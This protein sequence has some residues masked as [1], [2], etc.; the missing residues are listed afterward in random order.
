V[1]AL[2]NLKMTIAV[3]L[4]VIG[5]ALAVYGNGRRRGLITLAGLALAIT[6]SALMFN[7]SA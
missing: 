6:G 4:C 3:G 5:T 7:P 2:P 1:L